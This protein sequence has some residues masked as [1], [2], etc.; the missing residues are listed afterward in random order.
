MTSEGTHRSRALALVESLQARHVARL[1][2]FARAAGAPVRFTPRSWQRDEGRHGGGTR[3]QAMGGAFD[4]ASVNVSSVHYDDLPEKPLASATALSAIVH[5]AHP[6]AASMHMHVSWTARKDGRAYWRIMADLNPALPDPTQ[7][8]RFR[9]ALEAAA[10]PWLDQGVENGDRYFHIPALD[11][12]RGVCH[13]YLEGLDS[14][15]F[16]ADLALG[17]AVESAVIETY[18]ALITAAAAGVDP[19]TPAEEAAQLEYHTVYLF[20]VLT[21]DRG[22]TSG[23]MVHGD[24]DVGIL[25]SLPSHVDRDLLASWR[26]RVPAIQAPLVDALVAAL[27]PGPRSPVDVPA[28]RRLAAAVR[29]HYQAHPSALALQARGSVLPPTVANHAGRG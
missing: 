29:A 5:P 11:R 4:R 12:H 13:F 25:G 28:K 23:L 20:Q 14:G 10:G 18:A 26:R 22:T 8:V 3:L 21:L 6:R 27:E 16:D 15:D 24:N 2:A 9:A 19:P 7:T 17:S 1:E